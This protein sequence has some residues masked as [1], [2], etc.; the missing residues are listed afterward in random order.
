MIHPSMNLEDDEDTSLLGFMQAVLRS[1]REGHH[2]DIPGEL[3]VFP[4]G[5]SV[6]SG[7]GVSSSSSFART[8]RSHAS[9]AND[10]SAGRAPDN[11]LEID[12]SDDEVELIHIA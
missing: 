12:D 5:G 6:F 9:N 2:G 1:H 10:V 8:A 4:A 11:P 7:F 3:H